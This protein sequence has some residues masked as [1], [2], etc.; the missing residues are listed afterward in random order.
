[1]TTWSLILAIEVEE[2]AASRDA[3]FNIVDVQRLPKKLVVIS[4][5]L[6]HSAWILRNGPA[7]EKPR[8]PGEEDK[9]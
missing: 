1:M 7:T 3:V 9:S 2:M 8:R 4:P 6:S 5:F